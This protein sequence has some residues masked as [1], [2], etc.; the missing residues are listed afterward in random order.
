MLLFF[1]FLLIGSRGKKVSIFMGT[2]GLLFA[3]GFWLGVFWGDR[4]EM[5]C[6][7]VWILGFKVQRN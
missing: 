5:F 6:Q 1:V 2:W 4:K 7:F 3:F